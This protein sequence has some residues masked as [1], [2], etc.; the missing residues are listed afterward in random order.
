MAEPTPKCW[1]PFFSCWLLPN[2]K[3]FLIPKTGFPFALLS[4]DLVGG[5]QG[6]S[7]CDSNLVHGALL[8]VAK[9]LLKHG[10]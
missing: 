1:L 9:D 2:G 6:K 8:K 10:K 7:L 4:Y 3:S 5:T